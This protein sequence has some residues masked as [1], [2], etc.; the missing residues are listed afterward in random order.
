[1]VSLPEAA[2]I[3]HKNRHGGS[4]LIILGL[5]GLCT[6]NGDKGCEMRLFLEYPEWLDEEFIHI[7]SVVIKKDK[8]RVKQR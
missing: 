1:M 8:A 4:V 7:P 2:L 3:N 6:S 5:I